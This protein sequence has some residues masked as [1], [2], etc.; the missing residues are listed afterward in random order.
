MESRLVRLFIYPSISMSYINLFN[1]QIPTYGILCMLGVLVAAIIG[2]LLSKRQKFEIFDF[3]LI[4]VI[5]LLCAFVGAKILAIVVSWEMVVTIFKNYSFVKAMEL[6]IRNGFVFYGGLIGGAIGLLVTLKIK[7]VNIYDYAS[8][9]VICLTI[10]HALGRVGCFLGGCCYGIEYDGLLSF[11]Y[12]NAMDSMTPIGVGLLPIQLIEA[13]FLLLSFSCLLFVY[14]KYNNKKF[15][16]IAY[17]FFYPLLRF[18]IEFF[19]G[20]KER[21][22]MFGLST[23]Q[24]IS[25]VIILLVTTFLIISEFRKKKAVATKIE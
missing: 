17:L 24:W 16:V 20:D 22:L 12:T 4:V 8:I 13:A 15:V 10:G 6:V 1:K 21:G 25:I 14:L 5:T 9:F 19:R 11:K 3:L 2:I 7:K 23:S 18:V